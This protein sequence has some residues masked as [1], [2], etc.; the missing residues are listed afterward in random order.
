MD[1]CEHSDHLTSLG[2][3]SMSS[4][5]KHSG[6]LFIEIVVLLYV[7]LRKKLNIYCNELINLY[8]F[9]CV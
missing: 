8:V 9:V 7:K 5:Q 4:T 1:V 3:F 6:T 2:S